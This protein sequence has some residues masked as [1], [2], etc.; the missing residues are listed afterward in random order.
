VSD[1]ADDQWVVIAEARRPSDA[2]SDALSWFT[3]AGF[4]IDSQPGRA[5]FG[6]EGVPDERIRIDA[7]FNGTWWRV[8]V[9]RDA[10]GDAA[11]PA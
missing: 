5:G 11:P 4:K 9:H 1:G 6:V 7:L 2:R 3:D 8:S 10:L